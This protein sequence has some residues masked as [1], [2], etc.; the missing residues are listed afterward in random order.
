MFGNQGVGDFF[1]IAVHHEIQ[2]VQGEVDAVVGYAAL[3]V[4]VGADAFAAVAAADKGFAFGGFFGLGFAFLRIVQAAARTFIA[5]AL[6]ACWLRPSW[7][8]TTMPVGRW[9]MRTAESVLLM[10]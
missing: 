3:R 2:L 9:V 6:L 8:S 7:H 10:C 1:Q 5:C 4:V